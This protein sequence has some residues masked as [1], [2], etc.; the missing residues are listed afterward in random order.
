MKLNRIAPALAALTIVLRAI[1]ARAAE[2][3]AY[4]LTPE[5]L[6]MARA[7]GATRFWFAIA[8]FL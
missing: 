1:P 8:S 7:L 6:R 2:I 3:T 5:R 4:T